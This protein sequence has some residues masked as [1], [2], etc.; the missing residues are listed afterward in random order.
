MGGI[1]GTADERLLL[2][3]TALF[4][5]RGDPFFVGDAGSLGTML[6]SGSNIC[7]GS[8][9]SPV[10]V[11]R[12]LADFLGEACTFAVVCRLVDLRGLRAGAGVNSS[13]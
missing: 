11:L 12:P 6:S 3:G 7:V 10:L 4:R 2:E 1:D 9:P 8:I 5:F 13:S